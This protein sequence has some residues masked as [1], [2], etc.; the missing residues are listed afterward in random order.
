[1]ISIT[2]YCCPIHYQNLTFLF[3][4]VVDQCWKCSEIKAYPS[5]ISYFHISTVHDKNKMFPCPHCPYKATLSGHLKSHLL[6]HNGEKNFKCYIC[7]KSFTTSSYLKLHIRSVHD[8]DKT[9]TCPRCP[10]KAAER[11]SLGRHILLAHI[12]L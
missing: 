2:I 12:T 3:S 4:G 6:T 5:E 10:Y 11:C 8:K 9:F 1:M 7:E